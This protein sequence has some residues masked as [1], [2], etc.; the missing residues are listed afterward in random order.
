[1]SIYTILRI[2][3][4]NLFDKTPLDQLLMKNGYTDDERANDNQLNLFD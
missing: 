2:L 4:V 1:M 3:S